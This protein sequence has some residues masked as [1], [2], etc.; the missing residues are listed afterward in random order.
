[1]VEVEDQNALPALR[2]YIQT[3]TVARSYFTVAADASA[4][5][6]LA[7]L[8]NHPVFRVVPEQQTRV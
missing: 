7:A 6:L 1:V 5:H 4:A 2:T 8:P 3:A